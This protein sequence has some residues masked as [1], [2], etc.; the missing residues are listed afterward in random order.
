[1]MMVPLLAVEKRTVHSGIAVNIGGGHAGGFETHHPATIRVFCFIG[2]KKMLT[3]KTID[4][5]TPVSFI[6]SH[7]KLQ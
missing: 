5:R 3:E 7:K 4:E 1:M 6:V 2:N